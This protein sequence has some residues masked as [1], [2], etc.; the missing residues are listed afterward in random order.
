MFLVRHGE[1]EWS[2]TGK[3][4]GR[5]DVP[6]TQKG[7]EEALSLSLILQKKIFKKAFVSPLKRAYETFKLLN[8]PVKGVSDKNLAEWNY[9]DYEGL[10]STQIAETDP[11]WA[12][13]INGAPGGESIYDVEMRAAAVVDAVRNVD[14]DV[15][16]VSSA[17]ILRA[18]AVRWLDLPI[19]EGRH[20]TLSTGSISILSYEHTAPSILLWNGVQPLA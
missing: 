19:A 11:S 15:L 7:K 6:L 8:L 9:G 10:T 17:H 20:L 14:G 3:H 18:I 13:F 1:T 5:T 16:L 4:T 12:V 2:L